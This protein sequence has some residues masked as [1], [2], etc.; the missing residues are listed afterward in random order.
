MYNHATKSSGLLKP[1]FRFI[2]CRYFRFRITC[3]APTSF[4][5]TFLPLVVSKLQK[6]IIRIISCSSGLFPSRSAALTLGRSAGTALFLPAAPPDL[7]RSNDL[8]RDLVNERRRLC[9]RS[10]EC[11]RLSRDLS[12]D[13]RLLR[14][15]C[16]SLSR[17]RTSRSLRRAGDPERLRPIPQ[18]NTIYSED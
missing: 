3:T 17:S 18:L 16:L 15:R 4:P 13:R 10:S 5:S 9:S 14:S 7:S 11:L 2:Y 6:P 8:D 12:R 1:P